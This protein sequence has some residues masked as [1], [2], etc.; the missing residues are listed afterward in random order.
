MKALSRNG[1]A[2]LTEVCV[3]G[4]GIGERIT[5][6]KTDFVTLVGWFDRRNRR[7]HAAFEHNVLLNSARL[8][9]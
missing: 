2:V 5:S 7:Q 9:V 8:V 6:E 4:K 3:N 1:V